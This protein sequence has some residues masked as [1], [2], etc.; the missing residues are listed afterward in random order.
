VYLC[1]GSTRLSRFF[2]MHYK[3]FLMR[4][5]CLLCIVSRQY[6]FLQV[7]ISSCSVNLECCTSRTSWTDA[8]L[9]FDQSQRR[10]QSASSPS[11]VHGQSLDTPEAL[12]C[13]AAA[14]L[15]Y[16]VPRQPH[17]PNTSLLPSSAT[18]FSIRLPRERS[19]ILSVSQ[20]E[21]YSTVLGH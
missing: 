10:L 5:K 16:H 11:S 18:H 20:I 14:H 6:C 1:F 3:L 9:L 12:M 17:V 19:N 4:Q 15:C 13:L 21:R 8:A 2:L 7:Q